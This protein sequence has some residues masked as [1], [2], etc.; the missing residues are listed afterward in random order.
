MICSTKQVG[1]RLLRLPTEWH[2]RAVRITN[3]ESSGRDKQGRRLHQTNNLHGSRALNDLLHQASD[4]LIGMPVDRRKIDSDD[5][6]LQVCSAL[7][8]GARDP[9]VGLCSDPIRHQSPDMVRYPQTIGQC[10][11]PRVLDCLDT[12]RHGRYQNPYFR[13]AS[14]HHC[15]R[16]AWL[17]V[18]HMISATHCAPKSQ[19]SVAWPEGVNNRSTQVLVNTGADLQVV[20]TYGYAALHRVA[21]NSVAD[22]SEVLLQADV[23]RFKIAIGR[24]DAD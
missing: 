22:G 20:D 1:W 12:N 4:D 7:N 24:L 10:V 5:L 13:S 9:M 16:P 3:T 6:L 23:I 21:S 17:S 15:N 11:A 8:C 19:R 14:F 18:I 2:R